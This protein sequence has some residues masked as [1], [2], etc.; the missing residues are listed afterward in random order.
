MKKVNLNVIAKRLFLG[1]ILAAALFIS[2]HASAASTYKFAEGGNGI[3][4]VKTSK[5]D[6][7]YLGSASNNFE[8]DVHYN[9]S[10]GN[11]FLFVIKDENG[12]VIYEK[13]YTNK[14]FHKK[15]ELVKADDI[16]NLS[17]N[18]YTD[19]GNLVQSKEVVIDTKYVEDVLVSIN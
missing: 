4:S 15:V 14:Q 3:D 16:K 8:F 10:K 19:K 12:D 5:L 13:I 18:I 6:V 17:F 11:S 2:M 7:K 1:N 9:N